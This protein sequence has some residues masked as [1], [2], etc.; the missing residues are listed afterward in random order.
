MLYFD[1]FNG[2]S[3]DMILGALIDLGL[4]LEH[5]QKELAR[6][7]VDGYQLSAERI[8]RR[9]LAGINFRVNPADRGGFENGKNPRRGFSG[10]KELIDTSGL[11]SWVKETAVEIFRRLA[12]AEAKVHGTSLEKVHF[13]EVGAT[14]SIVD[15]VGACIGFHYF[16]VEVFRS[17]PLNL[18]GGTVTFSHGTWPVPAPATAELISEF[19]VFLGGGHGELTTPT[20]AA[21]VTTLAARNEGVLCRCEKSGFG[22]GDRDIDDIPNM[23]RLLLGQTEQPRREAGLGGGKWRQEEIA[24]LEANL[25]DTDAETLGHVLELALDKGAL[26]AYCTAIQMKKSRPGVKLSI[27]CRREDQERMAS[28]MFRETTTLGVRRG[29][30]DRWALDREVKCVRTEYGDVR[31]KIAREGGEIVTAAPEYEDLRSIATR[32]QIPL[33][34]VRR[35][36]MDQILEESDE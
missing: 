3:G 9:G 25:D 26:D 10:I 7:G 31:V 23:L 27:L 1:P 16:G 34:T 35:K 5:L 2:V 29:N 21:I 18:G 17:A 11:D 15:I 6:L 22:A 12:V 8:V 28:M 20:G 30:W 4:P 24:L 14:D 36:V 32:L 13:H 19:P 33:R